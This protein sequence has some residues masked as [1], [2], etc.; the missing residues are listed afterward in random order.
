M[1]GPSTRKLSAA[2]RLAVAVL[3]GTLMVCR[4]DAGESDNLE[5]VVMGPLRRAESQQAAAALG[6]QMAKAQSQGADGLMLVLDGLQGDPTKTIE[7]LSA[8]AAQLGLKLWIGTSF[9]TPAAKRA[10]QTVASHKVEGLALVFPQPT[11]E[12]KESS[13]LAGLFAVR[14]EGIEL[15]DSIRA[16]KS[17]LGA[18]RKLAI[19]L[20]ASEIAP[21]TTL[22]RFVPVGDLVRDGT[23]D[24]VC[25]SGAPRNNFHRLRLLRD[26]PL[27]AGIF[28]DAATVEARGRL[29][30][31]GR[32]VLEAAENETCECLWLAGFS[33]DVAARVVSDTLQHQKQERAQREA[34]NR[35]VAEGRLVIDQQV[36]AR[37]ADN[38][39]TVH[40]VAQSFRPSRDGA[41]PLVQLFAGLRG[42]SGPLPPP[43]VVEI[44]A[45]EEG[46]P[47]EQI[48]AKTEIPA[49]QF[50]HE[51][52]YRWGSAR[53]D[54]PVRLKRDVRYWIHL[55]NATSPQ[56]SYI[57]R[58]ASDG[59]NQRG[60]AWSRRYDYSKHTWVFRVYMNKEPA[61]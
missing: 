32:V 61:K 47:G 18:N 16:L 37:A 9:P 54:P 60:A 6:D 57:W 34:L 13:D 15:G 20:A 29:G 11:G 14:R 10:A 58:I 25:L 39:A 56:G 26:T 23:L 43:L 40:G 41:I 12:P 55:P 2:R 31:T 52:A 50:G 28:L 42:C 19:C 46:K 33:A 4:A 17:T 3:M 36:S 48:L 30:L 24:V 5:L 21:E 49:R 51:P 44:R 7:H 38:L 27:R 53:F 35:A 22:D 45:D 8:R 59:A 1:I